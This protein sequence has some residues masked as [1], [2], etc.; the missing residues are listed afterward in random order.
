MNAIDALATT[1]F[2]LLDYRGQSRDP[3]FHQIAWAATQST[4]LFD[5][6]NVALI[7]AAVCQLIERHA[8]L[9]RTVV[10]LDPSHSRPRSRA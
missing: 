5:A 9:D 6:G 1:A 8:W 4:T 3:T 2:C 7:D 10:I